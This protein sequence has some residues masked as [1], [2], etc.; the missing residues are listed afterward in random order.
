MDVRVLQGTSAFIEPSLRVVR[1]WEFG[2]PE[3][4]ETLSRPERISITFL[5]LTSLP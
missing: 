4:V 5:Y 2:P 1:Q 3:T